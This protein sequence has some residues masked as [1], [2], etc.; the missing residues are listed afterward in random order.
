[1]SLNK[2]IFVIY[3]YLLFSFVGF[4]QQNPI[5]KDSLNSEKLEEVIVT[6]TR[7]KRQLSSLPLPAQI[8]AKKE[9]QAINSNRLNE[10]LNEQTGLITVPDFGGGEGIQMQGLDSQYTLILIDGMPLIGRSAGTLDLNRISVGNIQQIEVVKGAS[11]SLY[12]NEALGGVINIITE[13]PKNGFNGHLSFRTSTFNTNDVGTNLSYK[14]NNF[15]IKTYLNRYSSDG[16]DLNENNLG[17][18]VTPYK[19]Y[20]FTTRAK[21]D[22]SKHTNVSVSARY[23]SQNQ[24]NEAYLDN[25]AIFLNGKSTISELNADVK[26]EHTFNDT[27]HGVFEF[28][29]SNYKAEENLNNPDGSLFSDALYNQ[30]MIRPEIRTTYKA[31]AKSSFVAGFGITHETL[32][33]T[34]FSAKPVFNAPYAYL[35]YDTNPTSKLNIIVGTRFDAH[36]KYESQLSPKLAVRYALNDK[37]A[38]KSSVGYGYKAPEFRQLYFD[39]TNSTVGYTV[40]GYN[41]AIER[42]EELEALGQINK[43]QIT[44]SEFENSLKPE[45]SVNYNLGIDFKPITTL[46]LGINLFR[47]DLK[48]MIDTKVVA[49]KTNGQ[50]VF[51]YFNIDKVYTQGLEFNATY[52]PINQLKISGGYQYLIAKDKT[53]EEKF[54]NGEVFVR[55]TPTSPSFQLDKRDYFGLVNRSKHMANFKVFY[56]IIKWKLNANLRATYRSKYGL[57]DTNNSQGYID[58]YDAFIDGYTIWDVAFNKTFFKHYK[59]SFGI[60]NVFDFKDI[61]N[62]SNIAGRLIYGRININF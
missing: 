55:L 59:V 13:T 39:F 35:Q 10:L 56:E 60:D 3:F 17:S 42:L 58:S 26:L 16:Y 40:L 41:V 62:I 52:K 14:K 12:G 57:F 32:D 37:I 23:Y 9:I 5:K 45:S 36:N 19:N 4:A 11:S 7:T 34:Y 27:W 1:M 25:G 33:R 38:I 30:V 47:N 53:A 31:S 22:F 6:A 24:D 18:T 2:N 15:S 44:L 49:Q 29:T 46:K 48:N 43:Y 20:T 54:K 21:Y 8:I 50:N 28:Y 51:S 61:Q